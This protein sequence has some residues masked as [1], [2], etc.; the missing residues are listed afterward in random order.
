MVVVEDDVEIGA[1]ATIARGTL[2]ATLTTR[3]QD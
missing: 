2:G 1:N 3:H